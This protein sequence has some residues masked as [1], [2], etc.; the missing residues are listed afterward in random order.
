[1]HICICLCMMRMFSMNVAPY[2]Y[3]HKYNLV[4]TQLKYKM[5]RYCWLRPHNR[6]P[7]LKCLARRFGI[8]VDMN[9]RLYGLST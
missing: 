1:M 4:E 6:P 3:N 9:A 8:R 7:T 5:I 2:G